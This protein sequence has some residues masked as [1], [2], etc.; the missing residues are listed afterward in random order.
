MKACRLAGGEVPMPANDDLMLDP[1][2]VDA[3]YSS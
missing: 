3:G 2:C 1:S